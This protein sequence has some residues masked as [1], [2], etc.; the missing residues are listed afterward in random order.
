MT[1]QLDHT[2]VPARNKAVSG[3][4]LADLLGVPSGPAAAG[5]FYGVYVNEGL[6]LDFMDTDEDFPVSHFCFRVSQAEFDAILG[7]IQAAGI[8]Y[9]SSVHGP[10]DNQVDPHYGNVYWNEPEGHQ[11]EILTVSYAR[12]PG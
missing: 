2:I 6:T 9:R 11:W 5:P 12:A 7:R 8:P 1:I 3:K 10:V 4:Q